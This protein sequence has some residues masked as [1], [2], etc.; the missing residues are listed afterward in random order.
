MYIATFGTL[1]YLL[2]RYHDISVRTDNL[3]NHFNKNLQINR[4][5]HLKV[6]GYA[7]YLAIESFGSISVAAFWS[8]AN[9]TLTLASAKTYYG[10]FIALAQLGAIGGSSLVTVQ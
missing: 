8:F 9:S 5:I 3:D 7:Q 4:Y 1:A 2:Y 6:L 10:F